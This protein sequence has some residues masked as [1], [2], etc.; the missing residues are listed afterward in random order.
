MPLIDLGNLSELDEQIFNTW[1]SR[2]GTPAFVLDRAGSY[3]P[4]LDVVDA[5]PGA[6]VAPSILE[7]GYNAYAGAPGYYAEFRDVHRVIPDQYLD[8]TYPPEIGVNPWDHVFGPIGGDPVHY[9]QRTAAREQPIQAG[10]Y[11]VS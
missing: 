6:F 10:E 9:M 3:A 1:T 7:R 4:T 11:S 2:W 8:D 5:G